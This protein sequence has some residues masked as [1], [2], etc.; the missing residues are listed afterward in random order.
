MP[1]LSLLNKLLAVSAPLLGSPES[2]EKSPPQPFRLM[3][4]P[5]D[6][7]RLIFETACLTVWR[8]IPI[9]RLGFYYAALSKEVSL[10]QVPRSINEEA[11]FAMQIHQA[12]Q[13]YVL[14]IPLR[15][16]DLTLALLKEIVTARSYDQTYLKKV[17]RDGK[18]SLSINKWVAKL[19]LDDLKKRG[20][21]GINQETFNVFIM[22]VM[23]QLRRK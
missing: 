11:N 20:I 7:R 8:S 6:V 4:L 21:T 10:L 2:S 18:P 19:P 3:E 23:L 5:W 22:Q 1:Q 16:I 15:Y 12:D 13:P 14:V 9:G 17:P